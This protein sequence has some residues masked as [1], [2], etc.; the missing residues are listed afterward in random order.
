MRRDNR[1]S[2]T[3]ASMKLGVGARF[4]ETTARL[5]GVSPLPSQI[6]RPRSASATEGGVQYCP[7]FG[8]VDAGAGEHCVAAV[9]EADGACQ[10]Q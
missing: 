9:L 3:G 10:L 5:R 2:A 8:G 1:C 4:G 6:S 7:V